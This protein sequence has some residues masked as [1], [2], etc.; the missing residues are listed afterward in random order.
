MLFSA[1][2]KNSPDHSYS[3]ILCQF[4]YEIVDVVLESPSIWV[5]S[6]KQNYEGSWSNN[7]T[8]ERRLEHLHFS[9]YD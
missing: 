1:N 8:G 7:F 6:Q 4:S 9:T 3:K 5:K 2:D